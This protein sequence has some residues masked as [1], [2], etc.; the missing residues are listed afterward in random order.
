[1][2]NLDPANTFEVEQ[3]FAVDN[4]ATLEQQLVALGIH[5]G[6]AQLQVDRYFAHPSRDFAKTDEVL[7]IRRADDDNVITYKGPKISL[8]TKTRREIELPLSP[9]AAGLNDFT[10]LLEAL[11]FTRVAEVRKHRRHATIQHAG[12]DVALVLDDV[13]QVGTFCELELCC[14]EQGLAAAQ[15]TIIALA[16][17]L[18]LSDPLRRSYLGMLLDTQNS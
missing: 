5:I 6:P 7:R 18:G 12:R 2:S 10:A 9:K 11:G 4:P 14:D 15:D 16:N 8:E 1:M 3:K 13:D 17:K